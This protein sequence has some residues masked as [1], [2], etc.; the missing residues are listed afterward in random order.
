ML[1]GTANGGFSRP[2][3]TTERVAQRGAGGGG[4]CRQ[5][6]KTFVNTSHH[7]K[8]RISTYIPAHIQGRNRSE[9]RGPGPV[10]R[11]P[12]VRLRADQPGS[13]VAAGRQLSSASPSSTAAQN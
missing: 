1:A 12:A 10:D 4:V 7:E 11:A 3:E 6:G 13:P 9:R 5:R 8:Y 2:P